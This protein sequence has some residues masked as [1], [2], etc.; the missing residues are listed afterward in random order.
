[1]QQALSVDDIEYRINNATVYDGIE[2]TSILNT[3]DTTRIDNRHILVLDVTMSNHTKKFANVHK[4]AIRV[5]DS[6]GNR[7]TFSSIAMSSIG[8]RKYFM[9]AKDEDQIGILKIKNNHTLDA[10][11]SIRGYWAFE[12]MNLDAVHY[13]EIDSHRGFMQTIVFHP[14]YEKHGWKSFRN[15]GAITIQPN[16]EFVWIDPYVHES[17]ALDIGEASKPLVKKA[18]GWLKK[19]LSD[20]EQSE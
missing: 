5:I 6:Y 2:V 18:K 7:Y 9:K 10:G 1:M 20:D 15:G 14:I 8:S 3:K 11:E 17:I 19:F 13:L 16:R 12:I 4:S